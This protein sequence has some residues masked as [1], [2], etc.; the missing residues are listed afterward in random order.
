METGTVMPAILTELSESSL[1]KLARLQIRPADAVLFGL[2]LGH[3]EFC[4]EDISETDIFFRIEIGFELWNILKEESAVMNLGIGKTS[5]L[6]I[7]RFLEMSEGNVLCR[8]NLH[9]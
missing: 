3:F 2:I 6:F 1:E 9:R 7:E 4:R 8:F 5:G